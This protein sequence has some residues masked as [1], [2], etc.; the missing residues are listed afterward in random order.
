[1]ASYRDPERSG[2][3][4]SV[5]VAA[6]R[7]RLNPATLRHEDD[8]EEIAMAAITASELLH[9][10]HR[11]K[12]AVARTR[13]ERFV[14]GLLSSI[15]VIPFDL[16]VARACTRASTPSRRRQARPSATRISSSPQPPWRWTIASRP[17][18]CA[19]F[20]RIKGLNLVRW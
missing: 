9:G 3:T 1:M 11:L 19:A 20:P 5:F 16:H 12:G 18:I 7:G 14:E 13:A 8:N 6:E 4:T 2:P 17:A 10:V 15:P